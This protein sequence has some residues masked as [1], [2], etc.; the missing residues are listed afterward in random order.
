MI[1]DNA[2]IILSN[3][4]YYTA[5][6]YCNFVL[7]EPTYLPKNHKVVERI[8]RKESVKSNATYYYIIRCNE[9]IEFT[10]KQFNFSDIETIPAYD[11]PN[12]WKSESALLNKKLFSEK[13][14]IHPFI[15][16]GDDS[17]I[18]DNII[19][20]GFNYKEKPEKS[21][22]TQIMRTSVEI[23]VRNG[24]IT[25]QELLRICRG[26]K[27]S[28]L[29]LV[30]DINKKSFAELSYKYRY[31]SYGGNI[32]LC[33]WKHQRSD[34]T[35]VE[36]YSLEEIPVDLFGRDICPSNID[37]YDLN[38]AIHF[39]VYSD[40]EEKIVTKE[41]EYVF[42]HKI[43][44]GSYIRLLMSPTTDGGITIPPVLS[45][46]ECKYR[47]YIYNGTT[48]YHTY[49]SEDYGMHGAA[50]TA[51]NRNIMLFV[52]PATW[53]N[54]KWFESLVSSFFKPKFGISKRK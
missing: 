18:S 34:T 17:A 36:M 5:Q 11:H 4:D 32:P 49:L 12:L 48:I 37:Q 19:W 7:F 40:S 51:H 2:K 23:T 20:I 50:W 45:N 6:Q 27:I 10:I 33:Y 41:V 16:G 1:N 42:E 43:T 15:F 35:K 46:Q 24:D 44:I 22:S 39:Y 31:P 29:D 3:I 30:N 14:I 28:N 9:H 25:D 54:I 21:L 47:E 53:T 38:S 13:F 26:L 8:V 52:K